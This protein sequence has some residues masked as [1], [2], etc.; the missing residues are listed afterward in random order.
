MPGLPDKKKEGPAVIIFPLMEKHDIFCGFTSRAGGSSKNVY[1]YLN[2]AYHVGDSAEAVYKNRRLV[3][4]AVGSKGSELFSSRQVH[5]NNIIYVDGSTVN[6]RGDIPFEADCLVTDKAGIPLMVLGA[7]CSLILLADIDKK[8]VAA[9][10]AG[11]K[12]TLEGLVEKVVEYLKDRFDC[13]AGDMLAFLGPSIRKCCYSVG[14]DMVKKFSDRFGDME[15]ILTG[16]GGYHI[17]LGGINTY[18]LVKKGLDPGNITDCNICSF[19]DK[20][21]YSYRRDENTGR[22]GAVIEIR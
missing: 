5:G 7:D 6:C 8:V 19:C 16:K 22:H 18:L 3:L 21:F 17:D 4:E 12:G 14:P 20:R 11:W 9:V 13:R 1:R 10:H 15:H 2:L